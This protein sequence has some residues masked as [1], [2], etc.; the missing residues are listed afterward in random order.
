MENP[1]GEFVVRYLGIVVAV[2]ISL[3]FFLGGGNV[4]ANNM[5]PTELRKLADQKEEENKVI[6]EG[7]LKEDLYSFSNSYAGDAGLSFRK[8]DEDWLSRRVDR[9]RIIQ[10]FI[11]SFEL[12]LPKGTRFV[13]FRYNGTIHWFDDI[14]YGVEEADEDW[15]EKHLENIRDI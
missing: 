14:N 3:E 4:D 9:D 1:A 15:A 2:I 10:E 11:N 13:A 6:K 7:F 8:T 12:V 5:T